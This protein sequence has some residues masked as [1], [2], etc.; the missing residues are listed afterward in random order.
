MKKLAIAAVCA[1]SLLLIV[2][3][4]MEAPLSSEFTTGLDTQPATHSAY[5][6]ATDPGTD[7]P[8]TAPETAERETTDTPPTEPAETKA[9]E[10]ET[11]QTETTATDTVEAETVMTDSVATEPSDSD[12]A[13]TGAVSDETTA[14][15]EEV[16]TE[17]IPSVDTVPE[18]ETPHT[19]AWSDWTVRQSPTCTQPGERQRSCSCGEIN[20][21][22]LP[23]GHT[24]RVIP[25][26]PPTQTEPGLT[27]GRKCTACG[28]ILQEQEPIPALLR[29]L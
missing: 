23:A 5:E 9:D 18:S 10:A 6:P 29:G 26:Y 22:P 16:T 7:E 17:R 15:S 20:R 12:S 14:S 28:E 13:S 8:S 11:T 19:H 25:G 27:D 2:F 21:E 4:L 24:E 1:V 3:L